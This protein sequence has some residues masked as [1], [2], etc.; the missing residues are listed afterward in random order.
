LLNDFMVGSSVKI[1]INLK[2]REWVNPQGE[3]KYFS[4][5]QGWKIDTL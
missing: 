5:L 4:S 2:G 1:S 3:A